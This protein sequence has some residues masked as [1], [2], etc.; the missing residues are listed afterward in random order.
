MIYYQASV[1]YNVERLTFDISRTDKPVVKLTGNTF[2]IE[3][4]FGWVSSQGKGKTRIPGEKFLMTEKRT[5]SQT[6]L[7][8]DVDYGTWS[9]VTSGVAIAPPLIAMK[10]FF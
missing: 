9:R 2:M 7:I 10:T 6:L 4:E 8:H 1:T 5:I 3:L